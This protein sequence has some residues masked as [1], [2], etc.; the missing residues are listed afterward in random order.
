MVA[1]LPTLSNVICTDQYY[2]AL[3]TSSRLNNVNAPLHAMEDCIVLLM[4][5]IIQRNI[6]TSAYLAQEKKTRNRQN[7]LQPL[8]T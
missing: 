4:I 2:N 3:M 7:E 1:L 6:V 8:I 5:A